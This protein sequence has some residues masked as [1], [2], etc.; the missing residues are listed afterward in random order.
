MNMMQKMHY[1]SKLLGQS[2]PSIQKPILPRPLL[3]K[4][5]SLHKLVSIQSLLHLPKHFVPAASNEPPI[6]LSSDD[7]YKA[8]LEAGIAQALEANCL[9]H[10]NIEY[11]NFQI[12]DLQAYASI[13]SA[14]P[15]TAPHHLNHLGT[16]HLHIHAHVAKVHIG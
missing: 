12:A 2:C 5:S 4:L 8:A 16:T 7:A 1:N 6:P 14:L 9:A 13:S 10:D 15:P 11:A 3:P